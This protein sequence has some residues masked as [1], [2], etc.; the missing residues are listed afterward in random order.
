LAGDGSSQTK[1]ELRFGGTEKC[2]VDLGFC[3]VEGDVGTG[4]IGIALEDDVLMNRN[5]EE[6]T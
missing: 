6:S 5:L 4:G 1:L 3:R 2:L